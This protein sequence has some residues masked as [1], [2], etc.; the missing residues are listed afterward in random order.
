MRRGS[1]LFLDSVE[2]DILP[3][4]VC[5]KT[6][7]PSYGEDNYNEWSQFYGR[8][9]LQRCDLI[10]SAVCE[11]CDGGDETLLQVLRDCLY[12]GQEFVGGAFYCFL[13]NNY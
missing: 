1:G 13:G 2:E 10:Q 8:L 6:P 11:V 3:Y 12:N 7:N 5:L 9:W 4:N